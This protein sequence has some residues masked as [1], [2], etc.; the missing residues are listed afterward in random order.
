MAVNTNGKDR[1]RGKSHFTL[2]WHVTAKCEQDCKHCYLYES[3]TYKS[4]LKNELSFEEGCKIIDD[5]SNT[6]D[7]WGMPTWI[8]FTGGDPL[9]RKDIFELISYVRE[10]GIVIG[11]LGNPNHLDYGMAKK[12]KEAGV[13]RYQ[14]SI[15]GL[16][17]THDRL[18]NIRDT[19]H[20]FLKR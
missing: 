1:N 18:R 10:R 9:T 13:T 3:P 15:D 12:L 5:F 16:E 17:G 20:I 11:I 7:R 2:Q 4:E 14:I 6:F 8:S 19:S